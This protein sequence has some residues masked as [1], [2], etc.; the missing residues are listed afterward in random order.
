MSLPVHQP[1]SI[2]HVLTFSKL[3]T[4]FHFLSLTVYIPYILGDQNYAPHFFAYFY[5]PTVLFYY[6][7]HYIYFYHLITTLI[8]FH[9]YKKL[10]LYCLSTISIDVNL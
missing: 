6:I 3:S 10:Y 2:R 4:T 1:V 5:C 8:L 9:Y 7:T